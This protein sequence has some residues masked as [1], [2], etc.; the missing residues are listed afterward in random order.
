MC[1]MNN[2]VNM[3]KVMSLVCGCIWL[4]A[5]TQA[6]QGSA[7]AIDNLGGVIK[8]GSKKVWIPADG[9]TPGEDSNLEENETQFQT[10]DP[11]HYY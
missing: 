3:I 9:E 11:D 7:Q 1:A 2:L 10:A 5:C 4:S 6:Q 8:S